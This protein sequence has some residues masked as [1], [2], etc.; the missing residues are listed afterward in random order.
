MKSG[1]LDQ[2]VTIQ[3]LSGGVDAIGQP[4]PDSWADVVTVW[5]AVEP[6]TGREY[7]A[8]G[9]MVSAVEARIRIRYRPG[10]T[11]AMRVLHG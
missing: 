11:P 9:A 2:R 5:A 3:A 7:L 10:V 1:D 6:L 8:A 4:L